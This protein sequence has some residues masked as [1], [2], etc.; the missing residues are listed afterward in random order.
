MSLP[1]AYLV[2]AAVCGSILIPASLAAQADRQ[3]FNVPSQ[4]LEASI[5][6]VALQS[7]TSI[8]APA[9]SVAH[10]RAPALR[11]RYTVEEAVQILLAGTGLRASAVGTSLV[12]GQ[13]QPG[14]AVQAGSPDVIVTGTRIAGARVS[15]T[16][17]TIDREAARNAGQA[18]LAE[19][20]RV[21]PQNFSGGQNPGIGF[22][23]PEANGGDVGGGS[24][25][26]LRGLGSDATLTLLNGRR[27]SYSAA[28]QSV[29]ISA[30]PFNAIGRI[31]VVPDGASAIFG[32]DAVAGV[33][34]VVLRKDLDGLETSARLGTSTDG[35]YFDQLYS[36]TGGRVWSGGNALLAYEFGRNTQ[37]TSRQR[38][39][40]RSESPGLTLFPALKHHSVLASSHQELGPDVS[41]AFDGLFTKRW[42]LLRYPLNAAGDLSVSGAESGSTTQSFGLAPSIGVRIGSDWRA[43]LD[44]TY[45]RERLD[46]IVRNNVA[47]LISEA[48]RGDYVNRTR[49]VELSVNGSV[50]TLP[51]GAA[52][53]AVGAGYRAIDFRRRQVGGAV[54]IIAADQDSRYAFGE[55]SLPVVAAEQGVPLVRRLDLS[56]A[57]RHEDYPGVGRVTTPKLGLIYSP[58]GDLDLRLSW[59]RSFRAPTLYQQY[60]PSTA[61]LAPATAFGGTVAGTTA[62]LV[63]GGDTDLKPERSSNWSAGATWHP[64][65]V[66]GLSLEA[67]YF[68][69]RYRDRIVTPILFRA[70]ALSSPIYQDLVI[71]NPST[72]A[73]TSAIAS[74]GSFVNASG[75]SPFDPARVVAIIDNT[76]VNAGSQ[77]V[78]GL[79]LAGRL[80]AAVGPGTLNVG[81]NASYLYS[82]QQLSPSQPS[83]PLAGI[84][85][86]PPHWRGRADVGYGSGAATIAASATYIGAVRDTR[87]GAHLHLD[88]MVPIDLTARV[89]L[90]AGAGAG[91]FELI[92]S[93]QNLF[94]DRPSV[95]ASPLPTDAPYDSTN[96]SPIG[97]FVSLSISKA[98]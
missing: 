68:S 91:G 36:A 94:N 4:P 27:L 38:D 42:S 72:A 83:T 89:R 13:T 56:A 24:S 55:L 73:L 44:A 23:V 54:S 30:I 59:G 52:K 35:G 26:N 22:N 60:Q 49:S 32:S 19:A 74:A 61:I 6:E 31:E 11:G 50:A 12:I 64:A 86:N 8:V 47:G 98:W 33:V 96:Y 3:E 14:D 58:V 57:L 84:I 7:R 97:R 77:R 82:K 70:V 17:I 21:V 20:L 95:I 16:V 63:V 39:Y 92:L 40:A 78:E 62:L 80:G 88:A 43:S 2:A 75:S 9:E 10:H 87:N 71:R 81:I 28:K 48:G 37:I 41:V 79:D 29:D 1:R 85:F 45:G 46:F 18:S 5:R 65:A 15:S 66:P 51:A 69:V 34:N 67:S 76:Y 53:L 90:G 25:V 93:L